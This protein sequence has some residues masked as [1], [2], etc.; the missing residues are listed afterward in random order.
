MK[1][2]LDTETRGLDATGNKVV[3]ISTCTENMT[4]KTFY[5]KE[6]VW[7]YIIDLGKKL[8]RNK[9]RLHIYM[10]NANYDFWNIIPRQ[11]IR[12][13][14]W[15]SHSPLIAQYETPMNKVLFSDT[16]TLFRM[17][18]GSLGKMINMP[19][20]KL[21]QKLLNDKQ[22]LTADDIAEIT[23][24]NQNDVIIL[25]KGL[26]LLKKEIAE[27]TKIK[28]TKTIYQIAIQYMLNYMKNKQYDFMFYN[29]NRNQLHWTKYKHII[30]DA[31]R[32]GR[33][34]AFKTGHF[35]DVS[36]IDCN[37][38]YGYAATQIKF[39][40]LRTEQMVFN[41]LATTSQSELFEQIGVHQ[42]LVKNHADE[43]GLLPVRTPVFAY[44][45]GE[46]SLMIGTWTSIELAEAIKNGYEVLHVY[47]SVTWKE[48]PVNPFKEYIP[49][50]YKKRFE[51]NSQFKKYLYKAIMVGCFGKLAQKR[52]T[53]EMFVDSVEK[54]D[55]YNKANINALYGVSDTEYM[56]KY[57]PTD[58]LSA[59]KSYYAPI[60]PC[61][62]NAYARVY[63]YKQFKRIPYNT[64]I[65]TDT[66][67]IMM[68]NNMITEFDIGSGIGQFKVEHIDKSALVWGPKALRVDTQYKLSRV[69]KSAITPDS[70]E[71][72]RVQYQDMVKFAN[73]IDIS[74]IGQFSNQTRNLKV[75]QEQYN[76]MKTKFKTQEFFCDHNIQNIAPYLPYLQKCSNP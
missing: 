57:E 70:F 71:K 34:E 60:I 36:Y 5:R 15:Y 41:P 75:Q 9:K 53:Q 26:I 74:V 47:K 48:A 2:T 56:Y 22:Q 76:L 25:M 43:L 63:M 10:H 23:K 42:C 68:Q 20:G 33:C 8:Y 46:G 37:N 73:D 27:E 40:D 13:F 31:Y 49:F 67:S 62:V 16:M 17:S 64:L 39:P 11:Q 29:E 14:K 7:N 38:L 58:Q 51:D 61:L 18:L 59:P 24:Y 32:G 19:K 1:L 65:Y 50:L 55:E 30:H 35:Q 66:D 45:P 6:D 4:V 69:P 52:L 54:V 44:Y 72:G 21:H 3:M 28:Y 12:E